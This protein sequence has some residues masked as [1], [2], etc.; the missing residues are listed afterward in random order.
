MGTFVSLHGHAFG[1]DTDSGAIQRPALGLF[2]NEEGVTAA[3]T[4]ANIKW[5]GTTTMNTTAAKDYTLNAITPA[6]IGMSKRLTSITTSTAVKTVSL[7]SATF[8]T[9]LASSALKATFTFQNQSL[10]LT[11]ISTSLV[12]ILSNNAVVTLST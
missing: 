8:L 4:A 7:T 5:R 10:T 9:T 6:T 12:Q 1:F 3:S 2:D 11:A